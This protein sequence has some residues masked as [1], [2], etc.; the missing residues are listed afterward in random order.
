MCAGLFVKALT[1][2]G[3]AEHERLFDLA[4]TEDTPVFDHAR[5]DLA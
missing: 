4:S 2:L 5:P 1:T 3:E